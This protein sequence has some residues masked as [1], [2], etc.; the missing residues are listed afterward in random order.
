MPPLVRIQPRPL[1]GIA[2][3][4]NLSNHHE[5]PGF[6]RVSGSQ[7]SVGFDLIGRFA[8]PD[9]APSWLAGF[10]ALQMGLCGRRQGA[11][12]LALAVGGAIKVVWRGLV[13][14]L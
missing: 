12:A 5:K 14:W 10:Y 3:A 9:Y 13:V 4:C 6:S 11:T 2:T 1:L 7:F 8:A